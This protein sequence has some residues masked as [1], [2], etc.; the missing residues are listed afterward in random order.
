MI[1][2]AVNKL[3]YKIYGMLW[4]NF[5]KILHVLET[6][7]KKYKFKTN[8]EIHVFRKYV[9]FLVIAVFQADITRNDPY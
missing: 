3:K 4:C 7:N 8:T 9:Y 5:S 2:T 1:T 6:C